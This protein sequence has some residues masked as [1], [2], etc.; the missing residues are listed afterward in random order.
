MDGGSANWAT[1]IRPEQWIAVRHRRG[2][3]G[4]AA[5]NCRRVEGTGHCGSCPI[6]ESENAVAV[7][8]IA[9]RQLT[10]DERGERAFFV[11][12]HDAATQLAS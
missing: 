1:R 3:T 9:D 4:A 7:L 6:E 10:D 5:R 2:Q 8:N 11:P 12:L